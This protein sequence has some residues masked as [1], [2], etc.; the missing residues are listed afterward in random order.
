VGKA[1]ELIRHCERRNSLHELIEQGKQLRPDINWDT[2]PQAGQRNAWEQFVRR[3][4]PD[5]PWLLLRGN[6][7]LSLLWRM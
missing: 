2:D 6:E 4:V 5:Q 3:I 1:R 7:D